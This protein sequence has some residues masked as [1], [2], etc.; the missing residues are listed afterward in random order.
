MNHRRQTFLRIAELFDLETHGR[1]QARQRKIRIRPAQHRPREGKAPGIAAA[2]FNPRKAYGNS[3]LAAL[4]FEVVLLIVAAG[5]GYWAYTNYFQKK[6]ETV[7]AASPTPT[8]DPP[9]AEPA[10]A[11]PAKVEPPKK[12][13]RDTVG[14]FLAGK[15]T[16]DAMAA[17]AREFVQ[18]GQTAGAFLVWR[19]AAEAGNVQAQVELASFYDPIDPRPKAGFTP[20]A[21]RAADWYERAA[22]A[23]NAEAQRKFGLLLAKGGPGL[24]A[25][26][27]KSRT[28]LQQAA[29]QNDPDAKKALDALPK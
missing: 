5:G 22:L 26:P 29:A 11:E 6:P 16:Q 27:V 2:R 9:K 17:K 21:A 25:D 23:G 28:W 13:V 3:A 7:A 1:L 14:E 24:P 10:K 8:P 4:G 20:D 19:S 15:P 12:S 18:S